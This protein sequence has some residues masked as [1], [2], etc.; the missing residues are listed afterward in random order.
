MNLIM[1]CTEA[2]PAGGKEVV[3]VDDVDV[4]VCGPSISNTSDLRGKDEQE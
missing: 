4:N 2:H 1:P 3:V